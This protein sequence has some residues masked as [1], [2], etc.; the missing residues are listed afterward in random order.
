MKPYVASI[1]EYSS[2]VTINYEEMRDQVEKMITY[3]R[4]NRFKMYSYEMQRLV[5][6]VFKDMKLLR[7]QMTEISAASGI[8]S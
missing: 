5:F 8:K 1:T 6:N 7:Q 2:L 4:P 3:V